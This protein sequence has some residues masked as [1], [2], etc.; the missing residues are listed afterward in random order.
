MHKRALGHA[1]G[2]VHGDTVLDFGCGTGRLSDWLIRRGAQVEGVDITPE[3]VAVAQ[4]RV[5]QARFQTIE[6]SA[7]PFADARFDSVITAYVL[8]YYVARNVAIPRE[9]AR[10]LREGG[11][12]I[13]IEQVAEDEIGRGGTIAAYEEMLVGAGL[14]MLNAS[15]IR[16]GD[17]RIVALAERV[18]LLASLPAM[19]WLVVEEAK[20]RADSPLVGGRY[21]DVLFCATK[22]P[23]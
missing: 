12:L 13:A 20:R 3:M 6:G 21:A 4:A 1:V 14:R 18:P 16:L 11:K 9:L 8:Q 15:T 2:D 7:L 17:S 5:P 22:A 23:A 10:V 19:P